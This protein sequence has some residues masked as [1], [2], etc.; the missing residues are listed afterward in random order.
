LDTFP[1]NVPFSIEDDYLVKAVRITRFDLFIT[2]GYFIDIGIPDDY[3]L[4]QTTL[5]RA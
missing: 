2:K 3:R 4:A 1:L 5:G